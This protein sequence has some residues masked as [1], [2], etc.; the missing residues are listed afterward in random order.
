MAARDGRLLI[1]WVIIAV[2]A[3]GCKNGAPSNAVI[4]PSALAPVSPTMAP[5]N[6]VAQNTPPGQVPQRPDPY[7]HTVLPGNPLPTVPVA[8][9]VY[10]SQGSGGPSI[11]IPPRPEELPPIVPVV[12]VEQVPPES[13]L[14]AAVRFVLV[15][16]PEQAREALRRCPANNQA[17]LE[18]LLPLLA[19]LA[20][21]RVDAT[22]AEN[23]QHVNEQFEAGVAQLKPYL[24][25]NIS[26]MCFCKD[27]KS[28]GYF[29]PLPPRTE[30][31]A[32]IDDHCGE[33][34]RVYLE[35]RN[36]TVRQ[37]G[38]IFESS[39]VSKL[40]I[41]DSQDRT[42]FRHDDHA[43]PFKYRSQRND[44]F[45]QCQFEV[46]PKLPP[47]TYTLWIEITDVLS[48]RPHVAHK[49]IEMRITSSGALTTGG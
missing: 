24:P 11:V 18:I 48:D 45:L 33:M 13:A 3:P 4:G 15:N 21:G 10:P 40:E 8:Q 26:Q 28:F 6:Q 36:L 35:L 7:A 41:R 14:L 2:F 49:A 29:E 44:V 19:D 12:K 38:A 20:E 30:F 27:A 42:V 16:R 47:G 34:V 46:P 5:T 43:P 23:V 9:T 17:L 22:N 31:R 39:L 37:S 1:L 25:L 32:G